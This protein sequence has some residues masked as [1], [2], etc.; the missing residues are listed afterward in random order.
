MSTATAIHRREEYDYI[1]VGAG[2]AGCV[3]ANRLTADPNVNVLLIEAGGKVGFIA[4]QNAGADGLFVPF[5]SRLASTYK[6]VPLLALRYEI[7]IVCGY[8]Q[9]QQLG[10][11]RESAG[12]VALLQQH[13][14]EVAQRPQVIGPQ[15]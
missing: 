7:P 11:P 8:A 13:E 6:S 9:P 2:S 4:D 15:P 14:G 12:R 3:L 5:F 10:N 1:I